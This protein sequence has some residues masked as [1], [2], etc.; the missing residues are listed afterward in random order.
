MRFPREMWAGSLRSNAREPARIIVRDKEEYSDFIKMYNGKMNVFTSVYDY[1]YFSENRGL[2]YSIIL[3]RIF[4]DFDAHDGDL[5]E[6]YNACRKMHGW[7]VVN[8]DYKHTI[9]FSGRGFHIFVYGKRTHSLRQIKAFFN[10]CRDVVNGSKSLDDLVINTSR[11]RRVQNT[12]HLGANSYCIPLDGL[13]LVN[14]LDYILNK[15]K[16]PREET[17][18]VY[19]NKLVEWPEVKSMETV[20]IEIDSVESPGNLPILP[21]LKNAIM[22]ENPNHR[23]RVL[24]VQWYNEMLSELAILEAGETTNIKPRE[25]TGGVLDTI[26]QQIQDEINTIAS[27]EDVWLDYNQLT[28]KGHVDFIVK[29][30]YMAPHCDTLINEGL[31]VGKCWRYGHDSN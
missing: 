25:I 12:Y 7:L 8:K 4:L 31:C 13:D 15:A 1:E 26:S 6:A 24:L 5:E 18:I 16:K 20:E 29:R 30:R 9:A 23:A 10:I 27:N 2:E 19:G 28:T 11:L 3:D 14:G 21:C 22:V 17:P